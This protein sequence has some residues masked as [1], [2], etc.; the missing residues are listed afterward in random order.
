MSKTTCAEDI[1][2]Y[3]NTSKASPDS[4]IEKAKREIA[5]AKGKIAGEAFMQKDGTAIYMILFQFG[6]DSF[7]IEWP[8]LH[9]KTGNEVGARR[10]AATMLYHDVKAKCVAAKVLG[11]RTAFL[12]SLVLPSGQ[13]AAQA[14]SPDLQLQLESAYFLLPQTTE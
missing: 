14:S 10:Q 12:S 2:H 13:T 3:W 9:S 8:V 1:G 6:D 7:R 4:W 5:S 11:A